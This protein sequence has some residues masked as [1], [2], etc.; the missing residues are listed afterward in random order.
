MPTG[1]LTFNIS[2]ANTIIDLLTETGAIPRD[3]APNYRAVVAGMTAAD[4][5][6]ALP[7]TLRGGRMS[8][9][10]IPLGPAPIFR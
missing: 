9:G 2:G 7:I 10:F 5:T 6:L 4:G 1:V 3:V 8:V